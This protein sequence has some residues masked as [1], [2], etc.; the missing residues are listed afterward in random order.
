MKVAFEKRKDGR[1][2][3][4]ALRAAKRVPVVCYGTNADNAVCSVSAKDLHTLMHSGDVV[5]QATGDL[6]GKQVVLKELQRDPVTQLV[7]HADFLLVDTTHKIERE[8]P[9]QLVGEAPALKRGGF[10]ETPYPSLQMEA[11]PQHLPGHIEVSVESLN[12]VGDHILASDISM[13]SDVTLLTPP[14][15]PIVIVVAQAA[16]EED[17]V[18]DTED[19][20]ETVPSDS[21]EAD[22]GDSTDKNKSEGEQPSS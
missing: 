12:E 21:P 19:G 8:V 16:E 2:V 14:D 6:E 22:S 1:P 4:R 13:P 5:F 20:G 9:I 7:I 10:V 17:P 3:A 15:T 18:A 11:L